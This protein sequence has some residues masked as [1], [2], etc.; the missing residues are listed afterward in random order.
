MPGTSGVAPYRPNLI[1]LGPDGLP[2][3]AGVD[4]DGVNGIDDAGELGWP[5]T[6]DIFPQALSLI[7]I[8]IRYVDQKSDQM[9]D[10]IIVHSLTD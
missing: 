4:D 10:V 9:R 7:R 6:D 1:Y 8:H 2:G 3:D 5:G